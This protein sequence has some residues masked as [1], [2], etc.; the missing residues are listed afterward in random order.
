M[1]WCPGG[2]HLLHV[3]T[4]QTYV[5]REGA[6]EI[7]MRNKVLLCRCPGSGPFPVACG[8][9]LSIMGLQLFQLEDCCIWS[10]PTHAL[11]HPH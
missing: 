9:P 5:E 8:V 6:L 2:L 7:D 10:N 3:L 4:A 1:S 11:Q